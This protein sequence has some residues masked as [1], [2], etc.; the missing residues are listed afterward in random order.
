MTT[1]VSALRQNI[2]ALLDTVAKTGQPLV[3]ERKGH[4][5]KVICEDPPARLARLVKHDCIVGNPED[6]V[7]LD[8][9]EEWTHDLP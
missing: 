3:I 4:R 1:S 7:H 9:S 5:L 6:L 8:W 2:Y